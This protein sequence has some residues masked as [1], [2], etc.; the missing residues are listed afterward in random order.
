MHGIK[1]EKQSDANLSLNRHRLAPIRNR[2]FFVEL[3]RFLISNRKWW[4]IPIVI[5]LLLFGLLL[6]LSS[7]GIAPFIYTLF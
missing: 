6:A 1:K 2:G 7:T 3:F 4:M 5:L